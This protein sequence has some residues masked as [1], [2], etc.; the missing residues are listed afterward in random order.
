MKQLVITA[1]F[2]GMLFQGCATSY[3]SVGFAGGYSETRLDKNVFKVSFAGN[4]YT[5]RERATDFAF[6]RSAELAL[7]HG[8]KYFVV[9]KENSYTEYGRRQTYIFSKPSS[10]NTIVCFEEKPAEG[11]AYSAKFIYESITQKYGIT[12]EN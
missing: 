4:G 2:L 6:L 11:F 1:C 10:S 9:I 8:Y 3:Q 7:Q 5:G 12:S